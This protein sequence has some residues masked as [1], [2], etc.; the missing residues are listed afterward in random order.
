MVWRRKGRSLDGLD[1]V[2]SVTWTRRVEIPSFSSAPLMN[3]Q[4]AVM[5]TGTL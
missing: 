2:T 1:V 4:L 5:S 3:T